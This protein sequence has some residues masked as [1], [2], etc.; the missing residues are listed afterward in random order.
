[1]KA[2]A[3]KMTN[4]VALSQR[5]RGAITKKAMMKVEELERE[6]KQ[7]QAEK[8]TAEAAHRSPE[9][10]AELKAR[11]ERIFAKLQEVRAETKAQQDAINAKIGDSEKTAKEAALEAKVISA[12]MAKKDQE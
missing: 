7:V 6:F 9:E 12:V 5:D 1:M 3:E 10:I 2:L 8:E 4:F 11:Q